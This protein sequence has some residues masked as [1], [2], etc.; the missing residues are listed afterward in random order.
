MELKELE[1]T[2]ES[3]KTQISLLQALI[4][5]KDALILELQKNQILKQ[6]PIINPFMPSVPFTPV[7]YTHLTLPTNREV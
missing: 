2:I 1:Q 7:S 6:N 4:A 5:S 3:L